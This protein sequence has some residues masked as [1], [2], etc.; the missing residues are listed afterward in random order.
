MSSRVK[1]HVD[2]YGTNTRLW[3]TAYNMYIA[4]LAPTADPIYN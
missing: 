3:G 1:T 2:K 4:V